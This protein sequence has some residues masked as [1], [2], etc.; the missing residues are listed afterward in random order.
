[1]KTK[2]K[3]LA[4]LCAV[5]I[6][7]VSLFL[8]NIVIALPPG[9]ASA[10][11]LPPAP[12]ND[13]IQNYITLY[14]MSTSSCYLKDSLSA[15]DV[16]TY[17]WGVNDGKLYSHGYSFPEGQ[18]NALWGCQ[19][20]ITKIAPLWQK[21]TGYQNDSVSF[22]KKI[23]YSC[24]ADNACSLGSSNALSLLIKLLQKESPEGHNVMDYI[25]VSGTLIS[26][27]DGLKYAIWLDTFTGADGNDAGG[28]AATYLSAYGDPSLHT[29]NQI[30]AMAG[31]HGVGTRGSS[32]TEK[33]VINAVQEDG[34]RVLD[35]Y[36]ADEVGHTVTVLDGV[37]ASN[38][39]VD[40]NNPFGPAAGN[41]SCGQVAAVL[42]QSKSPQDHHF[43]GSPNFVDKNDSW[44]NAYA[45]IVKNDPTAKNRID[46]NNPGNNGAPS[47][48]DKCFITIPLIGWIMCAILNLADMTLQWFSGQVES[49]LFIGKNGLSDT[50][51]DSQLHQSW[52]AIKNITS[53]G[54]LLI[55][56]FMIMTQIFSFDFLSAYTVKK[57]LPRLIIAAILIQL[58]WFIFKNLIFLVDAVGTGLQQLILTP[59][60]L[61]GNFNSLTINNI[62]A[63]GN[64]TSDFSGGNTAGLFAA[65]SVGVFAAFAGGMIG[66]VV[67]ALG[68]LIAVLTAMFTL[69]IRNVLIFILL[70]LSPIA[71]LA[72]IL[73]GTQ[74]LWKNWWSN[75]SKLL[76]MFPIIMLLFA[77]GAI[78]AK[79]IS[80]A[81]SGLPPALAAMGAIVAYF[82]P[83]FLIPATFKYAGSAMAAASGGVNKLSGMV[84]EKNPLSKSLGAASEQRQAAKKRKQQIGLSSSSKFKRMRS[85]FSTGAYGASEA[86][87]NIMK[88]NAEAEGIKEEG[89]NIATS[90][91]GLGYDEQKATV[92]GIAKDPSKNKYERLAATHWLAEKGASAELHEVQ[93]SMK[94]EARMNGDVDM[95]GEGKSRLWNQAS[96]NDF[97]TIKSG[98]ADIVGKFDETS[99]ATFATQKQDTF[100][101]LQ[102]HVATLQDT[103]TDASKTAA[104]RQAAKA[105]GDKIVKTLY[106]LKNS[107]AYVNVA[108]EIKNQ[109][110]D[111][112]TGTFKHTDPTKI[113]KHGRNIS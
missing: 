54:I 68:V 88:A 48:Y 34:S 81:G 15:T 112:T 17:N 104:Q 65:M 95:N 37:G 63:S 102:D 64:G 74:G 58:S 109:I 66:L 3:K 42:F 7:I 22:L 9:H 35:I 93:A 40:N 12:I 36:T 32:T 78:G 28:C 84:K 51:A 23:G 105:E 14:L 103:A 19:T 82:G 33:Y 75:F 29:N 1:M 108:P 110:D 89:L 73:P 113:D 11:N 43:N 91:K 67:I 4:L 70:V 27:S 44:A 100:N 24:G 20:F 30:M 50:G 99:A 5:N 25:N 96:D 86:G 18:D 107:E 69:I 53:V 72:W 45:E 94:E 83:L 52:S 56:L 55:G 21:Y 39:S 47:P 85:G 49:L 62:L 71:L 90:I 97:A 98:A 6:F 38:G 10:A 60:S 101:R 106:D 76:F 8:S 79:I 111:M 80:S 46:T 13:I 2:L 92:M 87:R 61:N 31:T 59:F 26:P 16:A 77:G 41:T 57:V